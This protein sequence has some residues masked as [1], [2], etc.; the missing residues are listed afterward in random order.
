MSTVD[1]RLARQAH[2]S[3]CRW[4]KW[5]LDSIQRD[6]GGDIADVGKLEELACV[7][8]WRRQIETPY[9]HL[10]QSERVSDHAEASEVAATLVPDDDRVRDLVQ[11][12]QV[13]LGWGPAEIFEGAMA[14]LYR[15]SLGA[16]PKAATMLLEHALKGAPW[17]RSG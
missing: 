3:W 6:W 12:F 11:A 7:Q 2:E 8:R 4:A 13:H 9:E 17:K 16:S 14:W 15:W 1:E 10:P 5:M